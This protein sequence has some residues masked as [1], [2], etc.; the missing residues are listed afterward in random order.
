MHA[1]L[2]SPRGGGAGI[3]GIVL[4]DDSGKIRHQQGTSVCDVLPQICRGLWTDEVKGRH[5]HQAIRAEIMGGM[6][7]IDRHPLRPQR[8]VKSLDAFAVIEFSGGSPL[9]ILRPERFGVPDNGDL[10]SDA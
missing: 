10:R 2:S 4:V 6:H 9:E 8:G 7:E 5:D 3:N 1:D